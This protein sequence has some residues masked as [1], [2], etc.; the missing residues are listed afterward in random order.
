MLPTAVFDVDRHHC[1]RMCPPKFSDDF[2]AGKTG[3]GLLEFVRHEQ[4]G[5]VDRRVPGDQ[6]RV[7]R[8]LVPQGAPAANSWSRTSLCV[9]KRRLSAPP[10]AAMTA[11]LAS[12]PLSEVKGSSRAGTP[13]AP[14]RRYLSCRVYQTLPGVSQL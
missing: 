9:V 1:R 11:R 6:V 4:F 3:V 12:L 8:D 13:A 7:R 14:P 5:R 2:I 10:S